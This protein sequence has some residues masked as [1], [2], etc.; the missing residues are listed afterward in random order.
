MTSGVMRLASMTARPSSPASA[1]TGLG[2]RRLPR[3]RTASG[4]VTTRTTSWALLTA[5][6]DGQANSGVPMKTMRM[7]GS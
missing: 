2:S 7:H 3:P 1:F 4:R 5:L 6:R